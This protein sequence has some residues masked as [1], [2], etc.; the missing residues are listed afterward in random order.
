MSKIKIIISLLII[1][2]GNLLSQN[3]EPN[4]LE[5]TYLHNG[6]DTT[7][8]LSPELF[9]QQRFMLGFQW[10]GT[11]T[12]KTALGFNSKQ[13]GWINNCYDSKDEY[14]DDEELIVLVDG[15]ST[16]KRDGSCLNSMA[17]EYEPTLEIDSPGDFKTRDSD[18]ANPVFGFQNVKGRILSSPDSINYSR[19]ILESDSVE[20]VDSIVLSEPWKC[21][22]L[23]YAHDDLDKEENNYINGAIWYLSLN[24]R[25]YNDND[26]TS[27]T[28]TVLS[29]VLPYFATDTLDA[30]YTGNIVFNQIPSTTRDTI[31]AN[32]TGIRGIISDETTNYTET[33]YITK[34]MLPT[35]VDRDITLSAGFICNS[36]FEDNYYLQKKDSTNIT[37]D[38]IK[39]EV[40]YWGNTDI[41]IDWIRL[42]TPNARSLFRGENDQSI[43]NSVQGIYDNIRD[44]SEWCNL[45][46]KGVNVF[47][48][49]SIDEIKFEHW[50]A[51][52]H[53]SKIVGHVHAVTH[54]VE[55]P[56]MYQHYI[57]DP[58]DWKS[59]YGIHNYVSA[60]YF[61]TRTMGDR[62]NTLG[63][64]AG[65][66]G[67]YDDLNINGLDTI[68][69]DYETRIVDTLLEEDSNFYF[70]VKNYNND[71]YYWDMIRNRFSQ[72]SNF[73]GYLYELYIENSP[74]V[75]SEKPFWGYT[76]IGSNWKYD[77][78]GL[79]FSNSSRPKT[80]EEIRLMFWDQII[81]GAKGFYC[82]RDLSD[83]FVS[84]EAGDDIFLGI[85][86][87]ED[88]IYRDSGMD[89][90][91][92]DDFL[93]DDF[94]GTDFLNSGSMNDY[95]N[96]DDYIYAPNA[97][98]YD[99]IMG[100]DG[101]DRIY[102]GRESTR[103]EIKKISDWIRANDSTL[104]RLRLAAWYGKGFKTWYTQ[105]PDITTDT[106]LTT[107]LDLDSAMMKIRPIDRKD[108]FNRVYYEPWLDSA[109][110]DITLLRDSSDHN[111]S[112]N[113]YYLGI[114]NRR[115]DPLIRLD[116]AD[117][118]PD[119][120]FRFVSTAE[121]DDFVANSGD[122]P[123]TTFNRSTDYW[124]EK[125]WQRKGCRELTIP[126]DY[127]QEGKDSNNYCLIRITELGKGSSIENKWWWDEQYRDIV[128]TV[129]GQDKDLVLKLLPGE[130]KILKVEILPP[131]TTIAGHL[132]HSN[133]NK[134]VSYPYYDGARK[135][136]S[137]FYHLVY[138]KEDSV[139]KTLP[140]RYINQVYYT[141]SKLISKDS[142]YENI[143]WERPICVSN[144]INSLND[145]TSC[146]YP[147][148]VVRKYNDSLVKAYIVYSCE[149]PP[150]VDE[151]RIVET[152][153]DVRYLNYHS[154]PD[155]N[156]NIIKS[157]AGKDR[158]EWGNPVVNASYGVNYYAWSDSLDQ[159]CAGYKS[160]NE[161]I[162]QDT[163][164]NIT[165]SRPKYSIAKH[166]SVNV[167]SH[168]DN[169]EDNCALVF[170]EHADGDEE[171]SIAYTRLRVVNDTLIK[172]LA[173]DFQH[174]SGDE[175]D[176]LYDVAQLSEGNSRK[177]IFPV[178]VRKL[179]D[180]D[181]IAVPDVSSLDIR[182]PPN[183][184]D[185]VV[186][187]GLDGI[188][189]KYGIYGRM[190]D[191][192]DSLNIPLKNYA[193][194][195]RKIL[196]KTG[197]Y[198]APHV[199][200][201]APT[202]WYC[203]KNYYGAY[204][205]GNPS[206][207][208]INFIDS[209]N[210]IWQYDTPF[211]PYSN[212][213]TSLLHVSTNKLRKVN[214]GTQPHLA[215]PPTIY[216]N[217][218]IWTHRRVFEALNTGIPPKIHTSSRYFYRRTNVELPIEPVVGYRLNNDSSDANYLV[219]Y[220]TLDDEL[221]DLILPYFVFEDAVY[222][223]TILQ[224]DKDTLYSESF[225]VE[226]TAMLEFKCL[227]KDTTKF[228][229]KIYCEDTDTYTDIPLPEMNSDTAA[230]L[231]MYL[232]NGLSYKYKLYFIN[233]DS[234]NG[235]YTEEYYIGGLVVD[236][237]V[238]SRANSNRY[239]VIDLN[240]SK[241][242]NNYGSGISLS[243]YPNPANDMIFATANFP[244]SQ[245]LNSDKHNDSRITIKLYSNLGKEIYSTEIIPGETISIPIENLQQGAYFL[246]AEEKTN[247][248]GTLPLTPATEPIII[249]R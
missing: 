131:D 135:T 207:L 3:N 153:L 232:I 25:R 144:H 205:T 89:T 171:Y 10:G 39:M 112:S 206:D 173:T 66:Y 215:Q 41:A 223:N 150:E 214:E 180:Y 164:F 32:V 53:F 241:V 62:L 176:I 107:L 87:Y 97:P 5:F 24:L 21:N 193:Y 222:G 45:R 61:R 210:Q 196:N 28:D 129:I 235:Y 94:V 27:G 72:Q 48:F 122:I 104:M 12:M 244:V 231:R 105:H 13:G 249:K 83:R 9:P 22:V 113:I 68:N 92:A 238:S 211:I 120:S 203:I 65:F 213:I 237:T 4:A 226:S 217:H 123:G 146:D 185:F 145:S 51:A 35:G 127:R 132:E 2:S 160:P 52:R 175:L 247:R 33:I 80:G 6:S 137:L 119:M 143:V 197:S 152:I 245:Y 125:W 114:L 218:D 126:F 30:L 156:G 187:Q 88:D 239:Y 31:P 14:L 230:V 161:V 124:K 18:P 165:P 166:P 121:F 55:F 183:R 149:G 50:K 86:T 199:I 75:Y 141:R 81:H 170:Q 182:T 227:G 19:L 172:Y 74:F 133:Q 23:Q 17:I 216:D 188:S 59:S 190:I 64:Y 159:I 42:E 151:G 58:E 212:C 155:E 26:N 16:N 163:I 186:W 168:I 78:S 44:T 109:F 233:L 184:Q 71:D 69:S 43:L 189:N 219:S 240:G 46:D 70:N 221:V 158:E 99:S 101:E 34:N 95:S 7:S 169:G 1:A 85:G 225:I 29:I 224:L 236:D 103:R 229:M 194:T 181:S 201:G 8:I 174:A 147:S 200:T 54:D 11:K 179:F 56:E 208:I 98:A 102:I 82:D 134:M 148:I 195:H 67:R 128:D 63:L 191:S 93:A 136:D 49:F 20:I 140:V 198:F 157:Y 15:I 100:L 177:G 167:Y 108:R 246:K 76:F 106:I 57:G 234:L 60:P 84:P 118:D 162:L 37:I 192:W 154:I 243:A 117:Q 73:E 79:V 110:I 77:K 115:T 142:D 40:R 139:T 202:A 96:L 204:H 36:S 111:F 116:T 90:L 220:P 242:N 91:A 228:Q 138:F 209:S 47:R 248:W 38:S 130:G 178:V